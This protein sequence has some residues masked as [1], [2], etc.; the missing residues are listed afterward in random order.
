MAGN[1]VEPDLLLQHKLMLQQKKMILQK[2][3]RQMYKHVL[4]AQLYHEMQT[5]IANFLHALHQDQ[6]ALILTGGPLVK[7]IRV[8]KL[9]PT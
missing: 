1:A 2:F 3:V 5:T 9:L 6:I 4:T 8:S 7:G